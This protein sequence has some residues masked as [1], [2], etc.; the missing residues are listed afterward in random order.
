MGLIG[1]AGGH[2]KGAHRVATPGG[3]NPLETEPRWGGPE[4]GGREWG[5][6][7]RRQERGPLQLVL[8]SATAAQSVPL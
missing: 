3:E 1:E 8:T 4:T 7:T 6:M 2:M 5:L